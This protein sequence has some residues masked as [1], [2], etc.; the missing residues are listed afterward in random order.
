[1][2]A[3]EG[4]ISGI[5]PTAFSTPQQLRDEFREIPDRDPPEAAER[6][7]TAAAVA[8]AMA[9]AGVNSKDLKSLPNQFQT[10]ADH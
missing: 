3:K 4:F 1:M 10:E 9:A 5:R 7:L 8:E 6:R 2:R